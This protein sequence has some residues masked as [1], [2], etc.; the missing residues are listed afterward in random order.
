LVFS[1]TVANNIG[2]G[3]S[4]YD[5]PKI[6]EAAKIA[7]A[8]QFIQKL[9]KGYETPIG[10][11]GH[12]LNAGER[13][14]I[15]LARAILRDPALLI[16]EEPPIALDDDTKALLDDT[17]ARVLPGRTTIFLPHRIST[18]RSCDRVFL[19]HNG[20]LEAA[21]EHRELLTQSELYRHLQYL[22]FNAFADEIM[23][24]AVPAGQPSPF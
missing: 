11:L 4:S 13:Y 12:S 9:P 14:R 17:Y 3:E 21:G 20:R 10:E 16:I 24:K 7:H 22:E 19:L 6:I 2:C 1:D 8:H 23:N 5:L 15:A 18:I